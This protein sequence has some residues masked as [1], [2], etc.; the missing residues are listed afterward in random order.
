MEQQKI[1]EK[2]IAY[3]NT[4]GIKQVQLA[5]RLGWRPQEVSNILTGHKPIGGR[6]LSHIAK[7][8]GLTFEIGHDLPGAPIPPPLEG[9]IPVISLAKG[10]TEG[11]FDEQGYP[12]GHGYKSLKRPYDLTDP[13]AYGV[14]VRGDSMVPRYDEKD[15][16]IASPRKEV[17]NGDYVVA[18]TRSGE[19]L[20]K[21]IRFSNG[22][23]ILE[24][25]NQTY[26]PVILKKEDV[27]FHH[28][29]V[30]VKPRG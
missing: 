8:L 2:L 21:R 18:K 26:P 1:I 25:V 11:F 10:G 30:W 19:V 9:S 16:V 12:V 29:I 24:S 13:N 14:E 3:M 7:T 22:M 17:V 6:R 23:V 5:E 15:V 20:V 28:K 27:V 4:E